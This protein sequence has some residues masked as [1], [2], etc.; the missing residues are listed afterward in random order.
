MDRLCSPSSM[1]RY[2]FLVLSQRPAGHMV[3]QSGR[4]FPVFKWQSNEVH[5]WRQNQIF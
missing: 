4:E 2:L 3:K 1:V 5:D